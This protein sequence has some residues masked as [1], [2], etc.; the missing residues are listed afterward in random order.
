VRGE[1][2]LL[3]DDEQLIR[4]SLRQ[5][6]SKRGYGVLEA[7]TVAL[8]QTQLQTQDVDL[9]I[10]DQHLPDGTGIDMLQKLQGAGATM[11]VVMLTAVDRSDIAVQAMKLGAFDYVTKPVNMDEISI[12]IEKALESTRLKRQIAHFLKEQEKQ[13]GFCGMIGTSPAMKKIFSDITKIAQSSGTTVLVVGESG[14]GKELAAKAIHFLSVRKQKP[15]MMVN[16]SALSES[17]IESELFGHEK[18]AF[19]D[20]KT[21]KK[22]IFELA[23]TGTIFLDEIG[24]VSS[25]IQVKL[26]RIIEQKSFQRVG[27]ASE[28]SVDVRVI[29]A[30]NRP[31]ERLIVERTFREDL[32]YRLNVASIIMPP[33][34]ERGEDVLLIAD[35]FLQE[36]KVKFKKHFQK[37]SEA[38]KKMF[39]DYQ[40]PGNVREIRNVLERALLL[41]DGEVVEPH[42]IELHRFQH[43]SIIPPAR[44]DEDGA[45]DLSLV[46]L[47]KRALVQ[48]LEKTGYNQS[49]AAKLLKISRD[50]L[51]YRMKKYNL[52]PP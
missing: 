9:I 33:I 38:T 37:F 25:K 1:T 46:E 43:A 3:V 42:H 34:R 48:A 26:L 22:G 31:L 2:I 27:G 28:I 36:F 52:S 30:T 41:G 6:L 39:L 21:Q 51:R 5:E 13:Y 24:D 15:L 8:A 44:V 10:L 16:C 29:A 14:T 40:W 47:E 17:L 7:E 49:R 19:T 12:V 50:T 4:W 35:Y 20:A 18:G 45:E 23:D 11:P 32:Y